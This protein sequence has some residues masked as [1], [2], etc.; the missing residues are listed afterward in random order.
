MSDEIELKLGLPRKAVAA[1]RRHP[2]SS[3]AE[4][5][6]NAVTLE[7]TYYDTA[8][9]ALKARGI[10]LRIRRH[11]RARLQTVK[12]GTR[13]TG[14]LTRRPEWEQPFD[15][16]FDFSLVDAPGVRRFLRRVEPDLVPV[17]STRFRR[18]T[19]VYTPGDRVRILM[20]IDTGE[21]LA[22]DRTQPICELELELEQGRPL[23][24]LL[25]ACRL[26]AD[27]PLLPDDASKA[28]RG[29]RLHLGLKP[30]P[31][32]AEI[33]GIEPNQSPVEAFRTLAFSCVRQWQA[34]AVAAAS[35]DDPEY[36]H[37]LRV[38]Q[39]RL[40]SLM[41]LFGPALPE[42]F[43]S[44]WSERLRQNADSFGDARDLDVLHE[45]ILRPVA[46]ADP[47]RDA[48][49]ARLQKIVGDARERARV[50]ARE[51]LDPAAQGRLL[52]GF[53]AAL[54]ALPSNNLIGAADLRRFARLQLTR[55]RR[56]I[57]KRFD[58]ARDLAPA[59]LHALRIGLK[60]L[61]YGVEFFAPLM[62]GK[63]ATRYMT[64]LARVQNALGFINDV[65]VARAALDQWAGDEAELRAAAVFV[66][67]WHGPRYA[68]LCRRS[69]RELEPLLYEKA[70]WNRRGLKAPPQ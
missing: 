52:I 7:N 63:A 57:R 25:L 18:E 43:V 68:R 27:I 14:G 53:M 55:L 16:S 5:I 22:G 56:K 51:G 15:G 69:I 8:D 66:C 58:S 3:A 60:Q 70:P 4:K 42:A 1:L 21:V 39:R 6:G 54:H 31:V 49:L 47:D 67:G 28:E 41:R 26:V 45:E 44:D 9:L 29:Y 2:L 24:L 10:A 20:M 34:N 65:D 32:R 17:F 33:S 50:N 37:Q 61:R 12:C 11:G 62:P 38:S 46:G 35:E 23:D 40:R 13:S 48:A 36:I 64:A 30:Q 59:R 19:R